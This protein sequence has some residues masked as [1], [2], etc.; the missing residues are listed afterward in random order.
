MSQD[1]DFTTDELLEQARGNQTAIWHLAVRRARDQDGSVDEWATYVGGKFAPS[2]DDLGDEASALGVA[3]ATARNVATTADMRPV[4]LTGDAGRAELLV[5]GPEE[6]WL[7]SMGA[8]LDDLDRA[9]ELIYR[10][11]AER[12]GLTLEMR[13]DGQHLRFV[14]ARR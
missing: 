4:E 14:F 2:W 3:R 10:R 11:I 7:E 12:R 5:Q 6:E 9:N 1:L 13:R 8:R